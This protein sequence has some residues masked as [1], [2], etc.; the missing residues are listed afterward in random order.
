MRRHFGIDQEAQ[1]AKRIKPEPDQGCVCLPYRPSV[2]SQRAGKRL[3]RGRTEGRVPIQSMPVPCALPASHVQARDL[4]TALILV[5]ALYAS[6]GVM[7]L[8]TEWSVLL[9]LWAEAIDFMANGLL[10]L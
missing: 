3:S 9:R 10:M 1:L 8:T 4:Q 5:L 6:V 2:P 7:N